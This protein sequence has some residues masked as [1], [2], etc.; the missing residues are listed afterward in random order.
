MIT[1]VKNL[2]IRGAAQK[3]FPFIEKLFADYKFD[4]DFKHLERMMVVEDEIGIIAVGSLC[5]ILEAAFVTD[6]TRSQRNKVV[7]LTAL[8]QQVNKEASNLNYKSF[9]VFATNDSIIK[10]LKNKFEFVRTAAKQV[11]LKWVTE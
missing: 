2:R 9:H 11:L 4:I 3:D 5:T 1:E 6:N 8:L 10:I 7:A